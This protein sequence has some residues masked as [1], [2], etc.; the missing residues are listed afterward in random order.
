ML[1]RAALCA[2]TALFFFAP[3][4]DACCPAPPAN[5]PVMNA[6][7]TVILVWD[8]ET[9]TEHFI[10]RAS[11][12]SNADD[13]GFLVPTPSQPE[14]SESG[15]EAFPLFAKITEPEVVKKERPS[16]GGGCCGTMTAAKS[17]RGGEPEAQSVRVLE[18]KS[19]A[20]FQASVLEASSASAL[21][22]WLKEHGYE[23]SPAV[24]AWAKPYVEQ[25]WKITALRVAKDKSAPE[26]PN[27]KHVAAAALRMSFKTD[28]PLFPYREPAADETGREML[29][30]RGRLLR[31]FFVGDART[32]ASFENKETWPGTVAWAGKIAPD[33]RARALKMLGL[34]ET[35]APQSWWLTE[36]EDPW[37]PKDSDL[38]FADSTKQDEVRRPPIIEY[39]K[40]DAPD[41]VTYAGLFFLPALALRLRRRR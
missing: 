5:Q 13:F 14:L 40:N 41:G 16:S 17:A 36:L 39:V 7:Q 1:K 30:T 12:E 11:F 28:R 25:K 2:S 3:P 23:L 19:V 33:V 31:I 20:G 18:Q 15:D 9:K 37:I 38:Y 34:P 32:Q 21:V 26:P 22:G 8:K 29:E 6:D 27:A 24:E 4:S 35:T 10:R